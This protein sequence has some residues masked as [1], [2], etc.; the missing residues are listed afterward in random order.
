MKILCLVLLSAA[1]PAPARTKKN[2]PPSAPVDRYVDEATIRET[3]APAASPGSLY[4]TGKSFSD[5]ARDPRSSGVDDL[6]TI[7]V[8]DSAS[9]VSKGTTNTQRKSSSANSITAAAGALKAGSALPNLLN[10]TGNT[11]LAGQGQTTR[12]TTL[13]TTLTARVSKVL[14]NGYL[15][16]EGYKEISVNSEKQLVTVRGVCRPQDLSPGNIVRSDHL[17]QL[18]VH[19]TGKGVI[20]DAVK[21]PFILYRILLGLMPF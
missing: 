17:A 5:L 11:Q 18:E 12:Q 20:N 16:L 21:R 1:L 4:T 19:V 3:T 9:A 13:S 7:L 14:P 15:M 6:V 10:V 2:G 8:S